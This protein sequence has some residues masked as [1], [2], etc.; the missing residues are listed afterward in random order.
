[1]ADAFVALVVIDGICCADALD[2][3]GDSVFPLLDEEVAVVAKD[4]VGIDGAE[5][6]GE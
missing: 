2:D 1:M 4:A 3:L 6:G 5:V